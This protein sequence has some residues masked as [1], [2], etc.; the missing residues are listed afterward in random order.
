M[1]TATQT[2]TRNE[3]DL[4]VRQTV[5][6]EYE[7]NGIDWTESEVLAWKLSYYLGATV[8]DSGWID[9]IVRYLDD[10]S[11]VERGIHEMLKMEYADPNFDN[12]EYLT[13][14][15]EG[16]LNIA[17]NNLLDAAGIRGDW[18]LRYSVPV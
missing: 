10:L 13:A 5:A 11:H 16:N 9:E 1:S 14:Y 7:E 4:I 2:L 6:A 3:A 12:T 8:K 17:V 15:F 18:I